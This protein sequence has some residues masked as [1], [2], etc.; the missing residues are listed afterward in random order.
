MN[1]LTNV[2]VEHLNLK[3]KEE[4][5]C[6][7]YIE[8]FKDGNN[9]HYKIVVEDKYVDNKYASVN[10]T[11]EFEN[12]VREFFKKYDVD[13]LGFSNSVKTIYTWR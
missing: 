8:D 1:D 2:M 13:K 10:I 4:G 7:R 11:D 12:M 6:L 5:T 3:L 9:T